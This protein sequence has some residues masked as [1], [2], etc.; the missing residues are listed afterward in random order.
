[1]FVGSCQAHRIGA[2]LA[3]LRRNDVTTSIF[4]DLLRAAVAVSR[5]RIGMIGFWSC[6]PAVVA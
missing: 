4:G 6:L 5:Y 1:V 2:V 3:F